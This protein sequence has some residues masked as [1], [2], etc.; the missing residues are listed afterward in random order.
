VAA[1]PAVVRKSADS[2][3]LA[4]WTLNRNI[5][6]SVPQT[7]ACLN[8]KIVEATVRPAWPLVPVHTYARVVV[9]N[10]STGIT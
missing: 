6:T 8:R 10:E 9:D 7:R 1:V 4:N 5:D 2:S 3:A